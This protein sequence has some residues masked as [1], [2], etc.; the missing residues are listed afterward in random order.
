[1][2]IFTLQ[3]KQEH[4]VD[5]ARNVTTKIKFDFMVW[6]KMK[7]GY[8][9]EFAYYYDKVIQEAIIGVTAVEAV[10]YQ[11]ATPDTPEVLAVEAVVGVPAQDAVIE[12][13]YLKDLANIRDLDNATA[14]ALASQI[15]P[16]ATA[17]VAKEDEFLI[18]GSF[19]IIAQDGLF[20]LAATDWELFN[21]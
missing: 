2:S 11:A 3:T 17:Y 6:H 15:T 13:V 4:L 12:K 8:R 14:D 18:A 10:E 9:A 5:N 7:D 21:G 19:A 20:G 1:M 16:T